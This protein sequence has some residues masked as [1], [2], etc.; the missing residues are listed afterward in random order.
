MKKLKRDHPDLQES[1]DEAFGE[2]NCNPGALQTGTNF[3]KMSEVRLLRFWLKYLQLV[4]PEIKFERIISTHL[5]NTMEYIH[6]YRMNRTLAKMANLRNYD[7]SYLPF[8]ST[9]LIF[10]G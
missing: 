10:I 6:R 3:H 2:V 1:C 8:K 4:L 5:E 7:V 9:N